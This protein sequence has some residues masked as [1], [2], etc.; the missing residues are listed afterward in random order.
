MMGYGYYGGGWVPGVL[1]TLVMLAALF[2]VI[3]LAI[4]FARALGL[5][6]G[7]RPERRT[8]AAVTMLR[9]RY[10]AGEITK[11][12]YEQALQA[13]GAPGPA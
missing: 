12:A 2:V 9:R 10:A 8:D 11:D 13:L 7:Q 1:M 3:L 4:W 6:D 5:V